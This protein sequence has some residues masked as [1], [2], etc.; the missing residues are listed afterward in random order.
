MI[1]C[2]KAMLH[3]ELIRKHSVIIVKRKSFYNSDDTDIKPY[4]SKAELG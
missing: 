1:N 3:L 2:F 4:F